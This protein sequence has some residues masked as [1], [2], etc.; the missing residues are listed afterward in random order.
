MQFSI[1]EGILKLRFYISEYF[2]QKHDE[3]AASESSTNSIANSL[4]AG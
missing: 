3:F 2:H 1:F 4:L